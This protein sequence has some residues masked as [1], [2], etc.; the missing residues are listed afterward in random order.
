[1]KS[2]ETRQNAFIFMSSELNDSSLIFNRKQVFV[3][4]I[5]N[6]VCI[7]LMEIRQTGRWTVELQAARA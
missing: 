3:Y 7:I 2:C 1:M 4:H 5:K 6:K